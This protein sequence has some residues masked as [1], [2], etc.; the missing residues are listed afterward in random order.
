MLVGIFD[1]GGHQRGHQAIQRALVWAFNEILSNLQL[2]RPIG[3]H[4][5]TGELRAVRAAHG[6]ADG[7][8]A[9]VFRRDGMHALRSRPR[10]GDEGYFRLRVGAGNSQVLAL[11]DARY[12]WGVVREVDAD[13]LGI[14]PG[15]NA[16]GF[17]SGELDLGADWEGVGTLGV[18]FRF[19]G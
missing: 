11:L 14:A 18:G 8:A 4:E 6:D 19:Q 9:D 10:G 5:L 15:D 13:A 3:E 1:A 7:A 12:D 17:A 2:L 16:A